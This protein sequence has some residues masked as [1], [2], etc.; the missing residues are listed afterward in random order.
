MK[1]EDIAG[2]KQTSLSLTDFAS[3]IK[4]H[5][6]SKWRHKPKIV[7]IMQKMKWSNTLSRVMNER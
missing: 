5:T 3:E 2:V 7:T 1:K 4:T 6:R